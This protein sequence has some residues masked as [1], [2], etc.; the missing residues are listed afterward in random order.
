MEPT[1][2]TIPS[3]RDTKEVPKQP[4]TDAVTGQRGSLG[5]GKVAKPAKHE[6]FD[7]PLRLSH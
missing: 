3:Q 2:A 6:K 1:G 7:W 4:A 5:L